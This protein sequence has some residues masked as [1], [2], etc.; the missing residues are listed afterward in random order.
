MKTKTIIEKGSG[1]GAHGT[2]R[3]FEELREVFKQAHDLHS[4]GELARAEALYQQILIE[5]PELDKVTNNLADLYMTQGQSDTARV[6]A[7]F[8]VTTYPGFEDARITLQQ[9]SGN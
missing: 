6:Y 3:N 9:L 1:G 5:I 2:I 4:R 8:S 7:R